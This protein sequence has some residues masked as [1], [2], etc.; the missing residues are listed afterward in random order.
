MKLSTLENLETFFTR[1][2]VILTRVA[3]VT[4]L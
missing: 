1:N 3:R 4:T 2:R